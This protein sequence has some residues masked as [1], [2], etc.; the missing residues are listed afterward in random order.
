MV[1][2]H[3]ADDGSFHI[4]GNHGGAE[5]VMMPIAALPEIVRG[6][7]KQAPLSSPAA[8]RQV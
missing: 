3:L 4:S 1:R 8:R 6:C 2:E 7:Y 5:M